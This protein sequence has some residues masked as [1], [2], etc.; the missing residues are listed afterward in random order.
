MGMLNI[1]P[2]L[3]FL[4][5]YVHFSSYFVPMYSTCPA[6]C[7]KMRAAGTS[8]SNGEKPAGLGSYRASQLLRRCLLDCNL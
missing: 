2:G 4:R 6:F 5:A 3:S 7:W 8:R 1:L